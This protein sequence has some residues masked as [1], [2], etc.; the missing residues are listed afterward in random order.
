M[1]TLQVIIPAYNAGAFIA[2]TLDSVLSQRGCGPIE[3]IVLDNASTDNTPEVLQ[4]YR[5]QGVRYMRNAVNVGSVGNHNLGLEMATADYLKLLSADDVLLPDILASQMAAL[6]L[7][8]RA[9]LVTC[10]FLETDDGLRPIGEVRMLPG[11]LDGRE[12]V[13][14]CARGMINR[15]GSPSSLMLRRSAVMGLRFDTDY[16]WLPDL[17]FAARVLQNSDYVNVDRFGLYY[18]RHGGSDTAVT[19][20]DELR[21]REELRFVRCYGGGLQA[22]LRMIWRAARRRRLGY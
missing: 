19:C 21:T 4:R 10:D 8:P 20:V 1:S 17:D 3:I 11:L 16:K 14:R 15:L 18:R 5:A 2:E 9:G 7:H 12:A 6:D 13:R 22:R